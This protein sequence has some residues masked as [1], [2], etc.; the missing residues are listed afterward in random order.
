MNVCKFSNKSDA[1]GGKET[2]REHKKGSPKL[3]FVLFNETYYNMK[4]CVRNLI[5]SL[6]NGTCITAAYVR[7][8]AFISIRKEHGAHGTLEG[9]VRF[10][11]DCFHLFGIQQVDKRLI[12]HP[13][14]GNFHSLHTHTYSRYSR[15]GIQTTVRQYIGYRFQFIFH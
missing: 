3:I 8:M 9:S 13:S 10:V 1:K 11:K 7:W 6:S 2:V 12:Y 15:C 14:D 4:H 5:L